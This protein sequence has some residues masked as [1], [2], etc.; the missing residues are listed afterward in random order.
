MA[1]NA[2]QVGSITKLTAE[3]AKGIVAEDGSLVMAVRDKAGTVALPL[4]AYKRF[5]TMQGGGRAAAADANA[6]LTRIE[7]RSTRLRI[8]VDGKQRQ[9]RVQISPEGFLEREAE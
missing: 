7:F 2:L 4:G 8:S 3:E 1:R 6:N 9:P 5:V